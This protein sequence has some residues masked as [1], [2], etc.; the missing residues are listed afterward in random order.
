ML[1]K[2]HDG[3]VQEPLSFQDRFAVG[4]LTVSQKVWCAFT[5][6]YRQIQQL[7]FKHRRATM[8]SPAYASQCSCSEVTAGHRFERKAHWLCWKVI[9]RLR[10]EFIDPIIDFGPLYR[11]SACVSRFQLLTASEMAEQQ[12][13]M[14]A[15]RLRPSS[16]KETAVCCIKT[17]GDKCVHFSNPDKSFSQYSY[18]KVFGESQCLLQI[19]KAGSCCFQALLIT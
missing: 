2:Q 16:A 13:T 9:C 6:I 8:R 15:V 11:P 19:S 10:R 18:D 3:S 4:E 1:P 14:V 5:A 7:S 17:D 12:A